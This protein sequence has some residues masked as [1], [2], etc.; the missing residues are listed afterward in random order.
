MLLYADFGE[1]EHVFSPVSHRLQLQ[2]QLGA[3]SLPC[4]FSSRR[5]A[6][7]HWAD[8]QLRRAWH[9]LSGELFTLSQTERE[10]MGLHKAQSKTQQQIQEIQASVDKA[11]TA[12]AAASPN[13]KS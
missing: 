9:K 2:L 1:K 4:T 5:L 10:A 8:M 11:A 3:Q 7:W 6:S 12:A 13:S